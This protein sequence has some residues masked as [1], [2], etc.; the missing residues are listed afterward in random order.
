MKAAGLVF[1]AV[2]GCLAQTFPA[3]GAGYGKCRDRPEQPTE[4][5]IKALGIVNMPVGSQDADRKSGPIWDL[6]VSA[7]P[8]EG[9]P[10]VMAG[11][12][13]TDVPGY[14]GHGP[15]RYLSLIKGGY[16]AKI[17]WKGI[18]RT[19]RF[20]GAPTARPQSEDYALAPPGVESVSFYT[21]YPPHTRNSYLWAV[22]VLVGNEKK[23][24]GSSLR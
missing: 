20:V 1:M 18:W 24:A 7:R 12:D 5:T 21:C 10:M 22:A 23:A 14:H 8:G 16:L 9:K 3:E 15:F 17:K 4:L 19:Y 13:V 6:C 2:L 11:H